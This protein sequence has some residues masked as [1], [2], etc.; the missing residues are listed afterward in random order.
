MAEPQWFEMGK[1]NYDKLASIESNKPKVAEKASGLTKLGAG[2][3][4]GLVGVGSEVGRFLGE[5]A[6]TPLEDFN[7]IKSFPAF[8]KELAQVR[9]GQTDITKAPKAGGK[10]EVLAGLVGPQGPKGYLDREGKLKDTPLYD[11]AKR[12]LLNIGEGLVD[13]ASSLTGIN[14]EAIEREQEEAARQ[15]K[16]YTEAEAAFSAGA[17]AGQSLVGGLLATPAIGIIGTRDFF[18][19]EEG[20]KLYREAP[21]AY[22][23]AMLPV[24]KGLGRAVKAGRISAAQQAVLKQKLGGITN[25]K[26]G[27]PFGSLTELQD[28]IEKT[29][30]S[31]VPEAV[32]PA[33]AEAAAEGL[34]AAQS[35][36]LGK[37]VEVAGKTLEKAP[38]A[39]AATS[40]GGPLAGAAV[41]GA[42]L[43]TKGGSLLL[44][45]FSASAAAK[46]AKEGSKVARA[47]VE[48]RTYETPVAE[49]AGEAIRRE[50]GET[51][52][53]E[54]QLQDIPQKAAETIAK[55]DEGMGEGEKAFTIETKPKL[56]K[57]RE[58]ATTIQ[59]SPSGGRQIVVQPATTPEFYR[60]VQERLEGTEIGKDPTATTRLATGLLLAKE[61]P[62]VS[63]LDDAFRK[64]VVKAVKE[65]VGKVS[66]ELDSFLLE[67]AKKSTEQD[68]RG[69]ITPTDIT[70]E[71]PQGRVN[72]DA[73][74]LGVEKASKVNR[75]RLF[76]QNF[77]QTELER[78]KK[79][80]AR[81]GLE[82]PYEPKG[83]VAPSTRLE[84]I[85]TGTELYDA[86]ERGQLPTDIAAIDNPARVL[87]LVNNEI[88]SP[89]SG[90][91]L[92]P[93]YIADLQKLKI[94]LENLEGGKAPSV[95]EA[96]KAIQYFEPEK[97]GGFASMVGELVPSM[98]RLITTYNPAVIAG[99]YAGNALV[100]SLFGRGEPI[101]YTTK[102]STNT[103]RW[104]R[105][106]KDVKK[107][108]LSLA[109]ELT[110]RAVPKETIATIEGGSQLSFAE[111]GNVP[112]LKQ[113]IKG[114]RTIYEYGD[115]VFKIDEGLLQSKNLIT[116]LEGMTTGD[117]KVMRVGPDIFVNVVKTPRGWQFINPRTGSILTEGLLENNNVKKILGS[118]VKQAIDIKFP[119][120]SELPSWWGRAVSGKGLGG[121]LAAAAL[122]TPFM[123]YVVKAADSPFRRGILS[124]LL[125]GD[126]DPIVVSTKSPLTKKTFGSAVNNVVAELGK[127]APDYAKARGLLNSFYAR[128]N[129]ISA[130][131]RD[132]IRDHFAF[133][134][135][136]QKGIIL[137]ELI[138]LENGSR[139]RKTMSP[140]WLSFWSQ[141]DGYIRSLAFI[142]NGLSNAVGLKPNE[143]SKE[144]ESEN[145]DLDKI[146][147]DEAKGTKPSVGDLLNTFRLSGGLLL[148]FIIK[149]LEAR[150]LGVAQ[151]DYGKEL[152]RSLGV[153]GK[154][155][156][157]A[158][159]QQKV[160]RAVR[161]EQSATAMLDWFF[162]RKVSDPMTTGKQI[163]YY[164]RGLYNEFFG[165]IIQPLLD[166]A[167]RAAP[168]GDQEKADFYY[169][170]AINLND[171]AQDIIRN[172]IEARIEVLTRLGI[173]PEIRTKDITSGFRKIR[174]LEQPEMIEKEPEEE[175][176][177]PPNPFGT[178]PEGI[179][180]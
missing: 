114:A 152:T 26:T 2:L 167:Q 140:S 115:K 149:S 55:V 33:A 175:P 35:S 90:G 105:R 112:V 177:E 89:S 147:L 117:A 165:G 151:P 42:P 93:N 168:Q 134:P 164:S 133:L 41:M 145:P 21:V 58:G 166:E 142:T 176:Y 3:A 5:A 82:Q 119:D 180:R 22:A 25:P 38:L 8:F 17:K 30:P 9:S 158:A 179:F 91:A 92:K 137:S 27:R 7:P 49:A 124:Y 43:L 125:W 153:A 126:S 136:D 24:L 148:P 32:G 110:L 6:D 72:L 54:R 14:Q 57:T 1:A 73:I 96:T 108:K 104:L 160:Q 46:A 161:A 53:I 36:K 103:L 94:N 121:G 69:R 107:G 109:D 48:P 60:L 18:Y 87:E 132:A 10:E 95:A 44:Q 83:Q 29:D 56:I 75:E 97:A 111:R 100:G 28:F 74:I 162:S 4:G 51:R 19:G 50:A 13:V 118:A 71:G 174:E 150:R 81:Q 131:D 120:V 169:E 138:D 12:D 116:E 78:A 135:A 122:F 40:I 66:P 63:L 99:N 80:R 16:T 159:E 37:A 98:K 47:V 59:D 113:L 20:K 129:E 86:W 67:E 144:L 130:E 64:R 170:R 102:A 146:V 141:T 155:F 77:L 85:T 128:Y 76:Q 171:E 23:L 79:A 68:K 173:D 154:G 31:Q 45:K 52:V 127:K 15:G 39:A 178:P 123:S 84:R 106:V 163:S 65:N 139:A 34:K 172:R 70:I 143:V 62:I 156:D 11:A 157:L 61:L 101:T 88:I